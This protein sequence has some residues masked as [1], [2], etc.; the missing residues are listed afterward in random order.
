MISFRRLTLPAFVLM[1]FWSPASAPQ[2][3]NQQPQEAGEIREIKC[4]G[5]LK[6]PNA[7]PRELNRK[8]D[9]RLKLYPLDEVKCEGP[10]TLEL[11]L[12]G[13]PFSVKAEHGWY[14][15]PVPNNPPPEQSG[16][17]RVGQ[18]KGTFRLDRG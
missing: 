13:Q 14:Q 2:Q 11:V 18:L 16:P 4:K 8:S 12:H 15:L 1:L 3:I 17:S 10:G 7:E 5:Y 9:K 6:R